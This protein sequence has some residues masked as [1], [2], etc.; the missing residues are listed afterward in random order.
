MGSPVVGVA[1]AVGAAAKPE[2]TAATGLGAEDEVAGVG[3]ATFEI[4]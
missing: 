2:A 1:S 4:V 3:P